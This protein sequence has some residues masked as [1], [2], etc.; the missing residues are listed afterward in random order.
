MYSGK[1]FIHLCAGLALLSALQTPLQARDMSDSPSG[2]SLF[3][4]VLVVGGSV[5]AAAEIGEMSVESVQASGRGVV[6]VLRSVADGSRL[7]L[8]FSGKMAKDLSLATGTS[9]KLV[10][11]SAGYVVLASGR[12]LGLIPNEEG[13]PL[14]HHSKSRE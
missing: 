10:A 4:S 9:V 3:A 12:V 11:T 8:E 14:L 5:L 6:V 7:T 1:F 13:K 2:L